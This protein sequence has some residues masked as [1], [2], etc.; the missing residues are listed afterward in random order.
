MSVLGKGLDKGTRSKGS[1]GEEVS[2]SGQAERERHKVWLLRQGG[3]M[4]NLHPEKGVWDVWGDAVLQSLVR[5]LALLFHLNLFHG[6]VP[7]RNSLGRADHK[8]PELCK[9]VI[10]D[11]TKLNR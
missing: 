3:A 11:T 4:F 7:T 2:C 10:G 9:P 1:G 5:K 8:P 6:V